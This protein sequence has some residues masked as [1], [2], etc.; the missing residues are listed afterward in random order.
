MKE[1]EKFEQGL[2]VPAEI[3]S[4]RIISVRVE[5]VAKRLWNEHKYMICPHTAVG[6]AAVEL[7]LLLGLEMEHI[8]VGEN[9]TESLKHAIEELQSID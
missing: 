1:L 2:E 3:Q 7:N 4:T 5:H 6:V 8:N 9:L